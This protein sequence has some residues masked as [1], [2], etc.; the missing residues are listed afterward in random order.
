[1]NIIECL[2]QF[3]VRLGQAVREYQILNSLQVYNLKK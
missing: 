1:M 2:P 3:D